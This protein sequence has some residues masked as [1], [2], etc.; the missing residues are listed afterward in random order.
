MLPQE[1]IALKRDGYA[2]SKAQIQNFINMITSEKVSDAQIAAFCMACF[3]NNLDDDETVSLTQS[4]AQSGVTINWDAMNLNGPVLDK[5]S[6]GG[7]GDKVSLIVAPIIAACGGYVGKIS[8]RGLGHTGGTIDKLESIPGVNFDNDLDSFK[9]IVKKVGCAITGQKANLVPADKKIYAIRDVTATVDHIGLIT[10][11]IVSKKLAM[12]PYSFVAD[13]KVGSGAMMHDMAQAKQLARKIVHIAEGAGLKT[14][15]L[16]TGM[17]QVLSHSAGNA[18]EI[19]E[20][21]SYLQG[22]KTSLRLDLLIKEIATHML[23]SGALFESKDEALIAIERSLSSGQALERF[24]QMV[25]ALGGP[26]DFVEKHQ[27]YLPKAAFVKDVIT[28]KTGIITEI[29]VE[30]IGMTIVE[31]GGGRRLP[32]DIINPSVGIENMLGFGAQLDQNVTPICTLHADSQETWQ[33]AAQKIKSA[34]TI[35]EIMKTVE[36]R[37][38]IKEVITL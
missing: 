31:M 28:D 29:D 9:Q 19:K 3:I 34:L 12:N 6:S 32:S 18:L 13:I 20:T 5:H 2:L 38:I 23:V 8:G 33:I 15:A 21:L 27:N 22:E 11:S 7:V 14:T 10:A 17:N 35:D 26:I 1:I 24:A 25:S 37:S 36:P 16:I 30:K 4:M